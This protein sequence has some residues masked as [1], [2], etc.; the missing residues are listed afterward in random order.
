M[1]NHPNKIGLALG[2]GSAR[3]LSHIGVLRELHAMK[4]YPDI[5]AGTS[6]GAIIGATY[7]SG[8]LDWLEDW[9]RGLSRRDVAYFMDTHL[10]V[11]GGFIEGKR[12]ID[13]LRE[14]I[15]DINIE[16]MNLT[17]GSIAT[18][19]DTG[20]EIWVTKGPVWNAVRASMALPGLFTPAK[21]GDKWM[22]DGGLVNPVPV[23]S[24]IHI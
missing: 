1:N 12:F 23:L 4:I 21:L 11:R 7:A 5:I 15:G 19:L 13:F 2:S 9:V 8:K 22:M 18:N 3:G 10:L 20:E 17:F 14:N 6:A 16:D 24:L